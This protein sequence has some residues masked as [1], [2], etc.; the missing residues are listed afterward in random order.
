M[1]ASDFVKR[2]RFQPLATL[3]LL[4]LAT[5]FIL[6]FLCVFAG[7]KPGFMDN[8]P[9]FTLNVTRMGQNL[10]QELDGKILSL[11]LNLNELM[12]RSEPEQVP[13]TVTMPPQAM[14]T[15]AP[16]DLGDIFD[17][18]TEEVGD[19][20]GE[21]T[22]KIG[23]QVNS[24]ESAVESK[25]TSIGGMVASKV[26]SAV[27]AAQTAVVRSINSTYDDFMD[28][29]DLSGFYAIH[30]MTTC[31]GE[32]V[33]PNGTNL[34]VGMSAYSTNN[35]HQRIDDC[36]DNSFINPVSLVRVLYEIGIFFTGISL[37]T[38]IL[39][40]VR[41]SR[42]V[43][44]LNIFVGA[45]AL[46]FI[47]IASAATHGISA[48]AAGLANFVG[49]GI[50]IA[51]YAGGKFMALT[52]ATTILLLVNIALWAILFLVGERNFLARKG[53]NS[54]EGRDANSINGHEMTV[55]HPHIENFSHGHKNPQSG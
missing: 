44:I 18:A 9:I 1:S 22:S 2:G 23:G 27:E 34:T 28:E 45:P 16:R 31:S 48:A 10:I 7:H 53:K 20:F 41:F 43:A 24:I 55:R 46:C 17:S 11:D 33:W 13:V 52:W 8:Y 5:A 25:A 29:L 38:A 49:K 6:S 26:S 4:V 37:L 14:I 47:G 35:T 51:G 50:G 19:Q 54:D 36:D 3:P 30:L 21:A 42:K 12:K 40:L 39:G 32:Y 15:K